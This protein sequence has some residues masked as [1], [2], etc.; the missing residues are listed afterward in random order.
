MWCRRGSAGL[1]SVSRVLVVLALVGVVLPVVGEV[2]SPEVVGA[3]GCGADTTL[4]VS[5]VIDASPSMGWNDPNDSRL[6]LASS[7]TEALGADDRAAVVSF[8]SDAQLEQGLTGDKAAVQAALGEITLSPGTNLSAGVFSGTGV[9]SGSDQRVAVLFSSDGEDTTG[10]WSA[11]D[12]EQLASLNIPV[13]VVGVGAESLD[14]GTLQEIAS[15]SGGVYF[16][17]VGGAGDLYEQILVLAGT[18][19]CYPRSAGSRGFGTDG[20]VY[21]SDP[22]NVGTGAF[23][24]GE[25][26]IAF[27]AQVPN[28]GWSRTYNSSDDRVGPLGRGWSTTYS[29]SLTRNE[30]G[31]VTLA[32]ADGRLIEFVSDGSGGFEEPLDFDGDLVDDGDG[33][34]SVVFADQSVWDFDGDDRLGSM[35][36]WSGES[37]AV[38]RNGDGTL[39]AVVSSAGYSLAFAY[40]PGGLLSSVSSSDGRSVAYGHSAEGNLQSVTFADGGTAGYETTVAGLITKVFDQTG[41]L[42]IENVYDELG[43]ERVITQRT[44]YGNS[45][46]FDYDDENGITVVANEATG[47]VSTFRFGGDHGELI[48]A[49][50]SAGSA[51]AKDYTAEG[52]L[53]QFTDREGATWTGVLDADSGLPTEVIDPLSAATAITYDFLN[54]P[55][56]ILDAAG[57]QTT[58]AYGDTSRIP[59][60]VVDATGA[61]TLISSSGGLVSEIVDADGVVW[62][63]GWDS[64]RN[65]VSVTDGTGNSWA[66]SYHPAG[67]R[68]TVTSPVGNVTETGY[69]PVGRVDWVKDAAGATTDLAWDAAGRLTAVSDPLGNTTSYAYNGAG[70]LAVTV[71]ANGNTTSYAYN[72]AGQL[73]SITEPDA[74]DPAGA[75]STFTY[76]PMSRV[77]TVTDPEGVVMSYGYDNNGLRSSVSDAEGNTWST[78]Y[79]VMGRVVES[80]DPDNEYTQFS[81]DNLGRVV[82]RSDSGV[83]TVFEYDVMGRVTRSEQAGGK[84][85]YFTYTPAGRL[86][87]ES[88]RNNF[89]T[90]YG[91]DAAGRLATVTDPQGG[92]SAYGYDAEGLVSSVISPAGRITGYVYDPTGRQIGLTDGEGNTWQTAYDAAGRVVAEID[93]LEATVSYDYDPVGNLVAVTDALGNPTAMGYDP[94]GNLISRRDVATGA[95]ESWS[96]DK[97][98]RLSAHIDQLGNTTAALSYDNLGRPAT[99][100]D[101]TGRSQ[102]FEYTDA[103]RVETVT[104]GD[105]SSVA[106]TYYRGNIT[107]LTDASGKTQYVWHT[108]GQLYRVIEPDGDTVQYGYD[109]YR[110]RSYMYGSGQGSVSYE[111]TDNGWLEEVR[112]YPLGTTNYSYDADG[113]LTGETLPGGHSRS[114]SYDDAGRLATYS[115]TLDG[116]TTPYRIERDPAGRITTLA[117]DDIWAANDWHYTYDTA[118]QL[119]AAYMGDPG[120]IE[121]YTYAYDNRG[122]RISRTQGPWTLTQSYNTANQLSAQQLNTYT[123]ITYSYDAAGR[124][125]GSAQGTTSTGYT[126]DSAGRLDGRSYTT[127]WWIFTSTWKEDY[128]YDGAGQLQDLTV[129]EPNHTA[130]P[131]DLSWDI[132]RAVPRVIGIEDE[133]GTDDF[134]W[135]TGL[136]GAVNE[137]DTT[138]T[139]SIDAFGSALRTDATADWVRS[140]NYTPDG[141]QQNSTWSDPLAHTPAFGYRSEVMLD[142]TIHL[143]NRTYI[144]KEGAFTTTDP[145]DGNPG[146]STYTNAYH[147]ADNDPINNTDPL[148]LS[149]DEGAFSG[150]GY[151]GAFCPSGSYCRISGVGWCWQGFPFWC[152]DREDENDGDSEREAADPHAPVPTPTPVPGL[153]EG[154]NPFGCSLDYVGGH[155]VHKRTSAGSQQIGI[156]MELSCPENPGLMYLSIRIS[157][158]RGWVWTETMGDVWEQRLP[159]GRGDTIRAMDIAV[160]CAQGKHEYWAEFF[161]ETDDP[162]NGLAAWYEGSSPPVQIRC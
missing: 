95:T 136:I 26:D 158:K 124:R 57:N 129:T 132:A 153:W 18:A 128:T 17:S 97:A 107:S 151:G 122:N 100:A 94:R 111:Y 23:T 58:L 116:A 49:R 30:D 70:D 20:A 148:G 39:G 13:F 112:Q 87:S 145:L 1:S 134:V 114:R 42:V 2:V 139:F 60:S 78:E 56:A 91:Y 11:E 32:D 126:Y 28:L 33:T 54:R 121:D 92:V 64:K 144:P 77:E 80:R 37:V 34:F 154:P 25:T 6:A 99:L 15:A 143:R 72:G 86:A 67:W 101:P 40:G 55:T 109:A 162:V 149:P 36:D 46:T 137:D 84:T 50:D 113:L 120:G 90:T 146:T 123:P 125:T 133:N 127:R 59:S 150:G 118:G 152:D 71:D 69:D 43:S 12:S 48:Q 83:A 14:S 130:H 66:F 61:E 51:I 131:Y 135:G 22:V 96:Y 85:M 53:E 38:S 79:D 119:S 106:Y 3:S 159:A 74:S 44:A 104:Y 140:T 117:P 29:Q 141:E 63:F 75:V 76:G 105:G 35:L 81:Y 142:N 16:E 147:Y 82:Q 88:N 52:R 115:Q 4:D 10:G 8:D 47:E 62:S 9:L 24:S 155:N 157:R 21:M 41:R 89:T 19:G 108:D 160:P 68:Q 27:S 110:R 102:A 73:A 7:L 161:A 45:V 103:G 5:F 65:L 98:D 31:S 138:A 156:K 93:P